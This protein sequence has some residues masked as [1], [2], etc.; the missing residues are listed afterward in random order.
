MGFNSNR[1]STPL[2]LARPWIVH[3]EPLARSISGASSA[4]YQGMG[5]GK[6][7][8]RPYAF[9]VQIKTKAVGKPGVATRPGVPCLYSLCC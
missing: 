4:S 7:G 2:H 6:V 8:I 9:E 3:R 1:S 5:S